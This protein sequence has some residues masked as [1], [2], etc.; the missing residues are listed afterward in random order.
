MG[1]IRTQSMRKE[2]APMRDKACLLALASAAMAASPF[3]SVRGESVVATAESTI[4]V[5]MRGGICHMASPASIEYSPKWC[6]V[7]NAGA[8]VVL[9]RVVHAGEPYATTNTLATRAADAESSYSLAVGDERCVRLVHRVYLSGGEEAGKELAR[10]VA[11]GYASAPGA[12]FSADSRTNS[13]QLAASARRPISLAYSTEWA[14]N[15]AAVAVDV[16]KLSGKGGEPVATNSV[17]AASAAVEGAASLTGL[18]IGWWR[19]VYRLTGESGDSLLEY[20]TDDFRMPGG[21]VFS[22]W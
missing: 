7:T 11:F 18:D 13:L 19:L 8:Y 12:V 20:Q 16:V 9:E 15:S 2:H 21:F 10:D 14:T 1:I 4:A 6:G 22:V 3:V 17:F 5:D